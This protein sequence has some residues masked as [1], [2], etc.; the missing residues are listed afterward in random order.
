MERGAWE[1]RRSGSRDLKRRPSAATGDS[2]RQTGCA[3]STTTPLLTLHNAI[4]RMHSF[5][6]VQ[7]RFKPPVHGDDAIVLLLVFAQDLDDATILMQYSQKGAG[8]CSISSKPTSAGVT[9]G[10]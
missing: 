6:Q 8:W 2:H 9:V 10:L 4:G 5:S 1:A 3:Q 7:P